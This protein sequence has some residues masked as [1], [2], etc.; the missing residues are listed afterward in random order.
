MNKNI[1]FRTRLVIANVVLLLII[2]IIML[3]ST[4]ESEK[5]SVHKSS[6][7]VKEEI[8][9]E[10]KIP[11]SA[12]PD[13]SSQNKN[14]E[15]NKYNSVLELNPSKVS[16]VEVIGTQICNESAY[17]IAIRG[18]N[19]DV[20]SNYINYDTM[21]FLKDNWKIN[22]IKLSVDITKDNN[23]YFGKDANIIKQKLSQAVQNAKM[24]DLF[25]MIEGDFGIK[26]SNDEIKKFYTECLQYSSGTTN[27][28]FAIKL[29]NIE[30]LEKIDSDEYNE[31]TGIVNEETKSDKISKKNWDK[32]LKK[33]NTVVSSLRE[34]NNNSLIAINV[35]FKAIK[36]ESI[37]KN[38]IKTNNIV[39]SI[40][41]GNLEAKNVQIAAKSIKKSIDFGTP[42]MISDCGISSNSTKNE[43]LF[44]ETKE[45]IY[46]YKLS[47]FYGGMNN[48][49]ENNS[50]LKKDTNKISD[51]T[52]EDYTDVGKILYKYNK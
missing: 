41:L 15:L 33:V 43:D 50:I 21:N 40:D 17:P 3:F 35:P 2:S 38:K 47:Y 34:N 29:K 26:T 31:K 27:L 12:N 46:K 30:G 52:E 10:N 19:I 9:F 45:N 18:M 36:L 20:N 39:F 13:E 49:G 44:C 28:M 51:F 16:A 37:S 8:E 32:Y 4:K 42:V 11:K 6:S 14:E 5:K 22:G 1:S 23:S 7:I 24:L 25:V 48:L